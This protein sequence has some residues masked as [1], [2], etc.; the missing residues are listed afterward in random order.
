MLLLFPQHWSDYELM[1]SGNFEKLERFGAYFLV[2]PEPKALWNKSLSEQEWG[3]L[4]HTRFVT[5]AGFGKAGKEDSGTWQMVRKMPEQWQINYRG[6]GFGFTMRLGLTAFKHVGVFP[7]QAP[8]WEYVYQAV[9][10]VKQ[11]GV[12]PKVLNLFAYTGGASLAACAAGADVT[13]LDAVRQV[14]TWARENMELSGMEGIRWILE[15]ALKFVKRQ[16]RR[17]VVYQGV[18]LDPPAYGHGPEG[19]RWKLDVCLFDLLQECNAILAP[20]NSFMLLNLYSNGYSAVLANTL[21][22]QAFGAAGSGLFGELLLEDQF[23]K[24]LPLSVF[25]RIER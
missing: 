1:D 17:G 15:D 18:I 7:E 6:D 12:M 2:R 14:V 23:G 20:Q 16:A 13:H 19:E 3:R 24:R 9:K 4:A 11:E 22:R 25:A 21:A 10:R 8:N 5:G